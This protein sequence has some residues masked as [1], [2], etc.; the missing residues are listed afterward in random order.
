MK[1]QLCDYCQTH[2]GNCLFE[3]SLDKW[4]KQR[5]KVGN[6]QAD[7]SITAAFI[8][9][10]QYYHCP[11]IEQKIVPTAPNEVTLYQDQGK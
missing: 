7:R 4:N 11:R 3:K 5:E 10:T 6:E 2:G 9:A 8:L 1:E